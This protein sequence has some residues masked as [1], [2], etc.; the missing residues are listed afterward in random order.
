MTFTTRT[1]TADDVPQLD[2]LQQRYAREYPPR[3]PVP[4]QFYLS[5]YFEGGQNVLCAFDQAG[6]L[7][8]YAPYFPQN[9]IAWVEVEALPGLESMAE[10]K[11]AL[12]LWLIDKARQ[13]GIRSLC[14]Q[15]YPIESE[16]IAF[17]ESRG[18]PYSYSIFNMRR[19]LEKPV[20][21]LPLPDGFSLHL[22]RME[23]EAEQRQ[24][25]DRRNE[26]FP[27]APTSIE[28]WQ[29]FTRTPLWEKGVNVA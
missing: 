16:A 24:Y 8:A 10:V 18:A 6:C 19:D 7:I 11:A 27:E 17:A 28:E 23:S 3:S 4:A 2:Q 20:P 5:P 1:L 25:L 29:Y 12:W 14:F 26:C 9:D 21:I 22:W 15:Y 13:G